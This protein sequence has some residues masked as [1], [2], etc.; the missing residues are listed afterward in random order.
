MKKSVYVTALPLM[1][2]L[3]FANS[4]SDNKVD[5]SLNLL[6]FEAFEAISELHNNFIPDES[7]VTVDEKIDYITAFQLQYLNNC[8]LLQPERE[9]FVESLIR[10]K[11]L[12][13]S[14]I[15]SKLVAK[16]R[17]GANFEEIPSIY[18]L[19]DEVRDI[20]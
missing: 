4:C 2:V 15:I 8:S 9:V 20:N 14:E 16:H 7:L 12:A 3:L 1:V 6:R 13:N 5:E 17:K 10:S 19:I 11:N 18:S